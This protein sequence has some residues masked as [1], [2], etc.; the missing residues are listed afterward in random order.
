M[1]T[2]T[3]TPAID[4]ASLAAFAHGTRLDDAP[5]D[6]VRLARLLLLDSVGVLVGG[7]HYPPVQ[8]LVRSLAAPEPHGASDAPFARLAG[9][10]TA[11]TWLDADSGGSFHPQGHRIP[12]VPTAHPAPHCLPVLL[13]AAANGVPDRRLT[14]VFLL[15]C[16]VGMRFGVGTSLRPGMHPHGIHGPVAAALAASLLAG[17]SPAVTAEALL[18]GASVPIAATLAVPMQGATVRNVWTGLGAYY[19]AAAAGRA[20]DGTRGDAELVTRL[21]DAAVC[22]DLDRDELTGGL[23]HRW[24]ITDSYLKPYACARWI[25]PALDAWRAAVADVPHATQARGGIDEI[26]VDTF[27]FA[28]SLDAVDVTSDMHARFSLPTCLAALA[29]EEDL[30]APTFLPDRLARPELRA[31]AARVRLRESPAHSAALPRERPATLTVRWHDGSSATAEVRGARGNPDDPLSADE[32]ERKF[33]LDVADLLTDTTTD[34]VVT[35]L[36][37]PDEG[38]TGDGSTTAIGRLTNEVL[39]RLGC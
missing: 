25:H 26:V 28:A 21:L 14:E 1:T 34:A 20:G 11:A 15:A 5:A 9:L 12:P 3:A 24:R 6:V 37:H 13:H 31:L 27:A 16:E 36:L 18:L 8:A 4:T 17:L 32:I 33:R 23:G 19:G 2:P 30:V 22:T 35:A 38:D 29:L 10:G 7:L 39:A